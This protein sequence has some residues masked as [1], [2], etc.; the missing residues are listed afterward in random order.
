MAELARPSRRVVQTELERF[1]TDNRTL[2]AFVFPAVGAVALVASAESLLPPPLAFNPYL[3]L[4]GTF[5]M[6]LPLL[7]GL[8][9]VTTRRAAAGVLGIVAYAYAVESVGVHTGVP[10]GEFAYGVDLGPMVAGVPLGLP[11]FFVPLVFDAYLL[12]L[13]AL[14]RRAGARHRR[15]PVAVGAVLLVDAVLDPGAVS[16]G[17]WTYAAPGAFYGVPLSN[18]A[19]WLLSA[20]VAVLVVDGTFDRVAMER[21]LRTC[22][23]VLD[24]AVS[25]VVLW[26]AV[27]G[28]YGN[29]LPVGVALALLAGLRSAG[30][31]EFR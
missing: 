14:G 8:A 21:R 18:F 12:T 15:V 10:Y 17:F 7:V 3:V 31:V 27:N 20:T 28:Y 5:V 30:R 26:G 25:F 4:F 16:L 29:W 13:L 19:G 22:P 9:P 23:F 11:L 1:V 24:D 2:V 6:R